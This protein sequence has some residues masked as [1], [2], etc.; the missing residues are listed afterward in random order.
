M[1][2]EALTVEH[3]ELSYGAVLVLDGISLRVAPREF[4]ALLGAS[5]CGKTTLLR[6]ISGLAPVRAG[7]ILVGARDITHL[8]AEQRGMAMVFQSYALWR[9]AGS[10]P[11]PARPTS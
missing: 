2:G 5:G 3:V 10:M 6:A 8:P 1:A 9:S 4:V 11:R 7:R